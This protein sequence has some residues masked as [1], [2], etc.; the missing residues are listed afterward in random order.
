MCGN[1]Y[2]IVK[3]NC[4]IVFRQGVYAAVTFLFLIPYIYG[5]TNLNSEKAADCLG[6]LTAFI[7]IPLF[8]FILK[9]EQDSDIRDVILIKKF[10]YRISILL[11]IVFAAVLS[12]FLIYLFVLYMLYQ[13]CEFPVFTY[14]MHTAEIS[15]M[16]G[17][18]GLL[19]S[20]FFRKTLAGFLLSVSF[21]FL[22]YDSFTVMVVRGIH[23]F[24]VPVKILSYITILWLCDRN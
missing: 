19:G 8:V 15:T 18:I 12:V 5:V 9:P 20:V 13:G 6:K 10:P 4:K 23:G 1:L 11:R 2:V 17:G 14:T 7:G 24:V 22:F 16:I 21:V 3:E